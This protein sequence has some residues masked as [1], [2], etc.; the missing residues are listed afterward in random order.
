MDKITRDLL[1][2]KNVV[3]VVVPGPGKEGHKYT[4]GLDTGRDAIIVGVRKKMPMSQLARMDRI[5]YEI[6]G[7]ETDVWEV[8]QPVFQNARTDKW[9]PA[10]G[11]VAVGHELITYGTLTGPFKK[12]GVKYGMSNNHVLALCNRAIIGDAIWQPGPAA[13]TPEMGDCLHGHLSEFI[14]LNKFGFDLSDCSFSNGFAKF[15]N[16]FPWACGRKTRMV[17]MVEQFE[18]NLVDIAIYKPTSPDVLADYILGE[19]G[20]KIKVTGIAEPHLAMKVMK[21]GARTDVSRDKINAVGATVNVAMNPEMT[22]F[23]IFEDQIMTPAM[24]DGGDSGS[25]LLEDTGAFAAPGDAGAAMLDA[26]GNI[27]GVLFAGSQAATIFMKFSNVAI[28]LELDPF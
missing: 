28:E 8:L 25:P 9:R 23:A 4:G 26:E 15:L 12:H 22:E 20:Q 1:K 5:P 16:F 18:T 2:K 27:V 19:G 11:G 14:W 10:P 13:V 6:K 17:P 3:A 21:P 7:M 24:S